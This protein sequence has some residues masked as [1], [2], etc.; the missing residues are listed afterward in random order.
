MKPRST[1]RL[2]CRPSALA[3]LAF[4]TAFPA[5]AGDWPSWRG[6]HRD[7]TSEERGLVSAWSPAG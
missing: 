6:P 7:G 3:A 2:S 5:G 1:A 4:L